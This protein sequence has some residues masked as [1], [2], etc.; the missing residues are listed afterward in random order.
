MTCPHCHTKLTPEHIR[1]L[2]GKLTSTLR[3]KR[4]GG[5]V[6]RKHRPNYSRCRCAKCHQERKQGADSS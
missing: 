3:H 5:K 2:W 6:W 4:S 1:S